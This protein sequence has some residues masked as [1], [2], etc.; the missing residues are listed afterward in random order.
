MRASFNSYR[1]SIFCAGDVSETLA[2]IA[3]AIVVGVVLACLATV[4]HVRAQAGT[5]TF[6]VTV[7]DKQGAAIPG[8]NGTATETFFSY[9]CGATR[10]C[11]PFGV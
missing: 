9:F 5:G 11:I 2:S 7:V 10:R 4:M 3:Y 8:A 6:S 1:L